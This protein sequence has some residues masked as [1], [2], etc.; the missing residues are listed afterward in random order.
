[1]NKN[2]TV[3]V[4]WTCEKTCSKTV[5]D[6]PEQFLTTFQQKGYDTDYKF[7]QEIDGFKLYS[8]S[9]SSKSKLISLVFVEDLTKQKKD[10]SKKAVTYCNKFLQPYLRNMRKQLQKEGLDFKFSK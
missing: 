7:F 10:T 5:S 9:V 8:M 4:F 1:M 2:K 6:T 3:G